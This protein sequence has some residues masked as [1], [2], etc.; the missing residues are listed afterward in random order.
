MRTILQEWL[1]SQTSTNDCNIIALG[2]CPD[3]LAMMNS[4]P[5]DYKSEKELFGLKCTLQ[6][7]EKCV[8]YFRAPPPNSVLYLH[9]IC[10]SHTSTSSWRNAFLACGSSVPAHCLHLVRAHTCH[11]SWPSASLT[12]LIDN[13]SSPRACLTQ[14]NVLP[15][16]EPQSGDTAFK[17][18]LHKN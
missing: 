13:Q 1:R 14:L 4:K 3:S 2:W 8:F 15:A 7:N 12:C 16:A 6:G 11:G 18:V 9:C 17:G 10:K 5:R